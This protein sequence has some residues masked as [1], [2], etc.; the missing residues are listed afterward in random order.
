MPTQSD[1]IKRQGLINSIELEI[2]QDIERSRETICSKRIDRHI[3]FE[4]NQDIDNQIFK[5]K[6][7]QLIIRK[8]L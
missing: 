7:D 3:K 5:G 4:T 2:L 8:H 1:W 6:I